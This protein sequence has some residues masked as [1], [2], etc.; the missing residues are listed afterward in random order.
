MSFLEQI[1]RAVYQVEVQC[2]SEFEEK[3]ELLTHPIVRQTQ[4]CTREALYG[5]WTEAMRLLYK[6]RE[7]ET[8]QYVDVMSLYPYICNYFNF[9]IGHPTVHVGDAFKDVEASVNIDRFIM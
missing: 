3:H 5:G 2:E 8:N 4:I 6:R 9:P 7:N 1:T